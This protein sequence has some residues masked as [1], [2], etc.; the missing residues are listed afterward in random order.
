MISTHT[1]RRS[2]ATNM[3]QAKVSTNLIMFALDHKT[4]EQTRHYARIDQ[5]E[6]AQALYRE[7]HHLMNDPANAFMFEQEKK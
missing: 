6:N 1:A 7:L 2:Y 4:E 3:I 5:L